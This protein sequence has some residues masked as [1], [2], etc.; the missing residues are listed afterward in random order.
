ME[1]LPFLYLVSQLSQPLPSFGRIDFVI[2]IAPQDRVGH[3]LLHQ[4]DRVSLFVH[5]FSCKLSSPVD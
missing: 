3:L 5:D 1:I 2:L 4:P